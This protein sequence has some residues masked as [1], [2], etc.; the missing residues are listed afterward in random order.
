M[1][2]VYMPELARVLAITEETSNIRT[3]TIGFDDSR[4]LA[5]SPGQ[6][7]EVTIFG[8][9]EFPVSI[10]RILAP[11]SQRFQITIQRRGKVT[12]EVKDM[13]VGSKIGIRGPFG[14]GFPLDV[15]EGKNILMVTGGVGL[16]A[17]RLLLDHL[18]ENR[19]KYSRIELL[20]GARTPE[21]LIYRHTNIF[22]RRKAEKDGLMV[23]L[24]VEKADEHWQG[25]VGLVTDLVSS[26]KIK[27]TNSIAVVCGP[28]A[29]MKSTS[30]ELKS[31]GFDEERIFL[32]MERRMQ[33]G[34]G[35]CGHCMV[36]R[37]RVCIDGPVLA[38]GLAKSALEK[39]L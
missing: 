16:A 9:G 1:K 24:S 23:V 27:G 6:F 13:H 8:Y 28:N 26:T 3:L 29:M 2:N 39:A 31:A 14:R 33:C 35:M 30:S 20:H 11:N 21:D 12:N 15:M 17:V 32:S 7:V 10:A 34:M 5:A 25:R 37:E 19:S 4:S 22:D 36:G 18:L 38:Y